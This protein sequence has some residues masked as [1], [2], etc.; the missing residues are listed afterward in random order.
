MMSSSH[1]GLGLVF[2]TMYRATKRNSLGALMLSLLLG[3]LAGC[4]TTKSRSAS[5]QL[6]MSD[7]VDRTISQIDFGVFEGQK[8]FFDTKYIKTI[9]GAGF[10]NGDY[11]ISS[12]RQQMVASGC[13][14]QDDEKDADFV[15]EAR[16]GTLGTDGHNVTYGI[17]ASTGITDAAALI[18][19][20]PRIPLIPEISLARKEDYMG[21]AKIGVFAYH[22]ETRRRV[23]Q[24]GIAKATSSA[25]DAWVLGA[26]PIQY[27]TIY[28]EARFAGDRIWRPW[29]RKKKHEE[30]THRLVSY[31]EEVDFEKRAE[32]EKAAQMESQNTTAGAG[33]QTPGAPRLLPS[34]L[35]ALATPVPPQ[36]SEI[37]SGE[38]K[39]PPPPAKLQPAAVPESPTEPKPSPIPPS[40]AEV[41]PS[42]KRPPLVEV[43]PSPK[44]PSP[45]EPKPSSEPTPTA[46]SE[47][48]A[49]PPSPAE[50]PAPSAK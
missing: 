1:R 16:V 38:T 9:K 42:P 20:A 15:L 28:D 5:D 44:P 29:F 21:A 17:P 3:V 43:K 46:K 40:P 48:S 36:D 34:H 47:P 7:A 13:L 10:V 32:Q 41:K 14:L 11:V 50:S 18:P 39:S 2:E 27:G 33:E 26:G 31:Y 35:D 45:V 6:L 23:W 49:K 37:V 12:L 24:S 4:G 8:V 25:N 30:P 19:T 22:R